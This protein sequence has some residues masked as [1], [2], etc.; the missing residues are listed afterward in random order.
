M[1]ATTGWLRV[2]HANGCDDAALQRIVR[3]ELGPASVLRIIGAPVRGDPLQAWGDLGRALGPPSRRRS[4]A[5][6]WTELRFEPERMDLFRHVN[7][8]HPLHTDSAGTGVTLYY[9]ERRGRGGDSL[10]VDAGAVAAAARRRGG[11]LFERLFEVP[12]S[13]AKGPITTKPR[14]ILRRQ[15]DRLK[16]AWDYYAVAPGQG[17]EVDALREDFRAFLEAMVMDGDACA[18][19]LETGDA[20]FALADEVLH[21]RAAGPAKLAGKP[22]GEQILWKASLG[23]NPSR[24]IR[25]A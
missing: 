14:P 6:A 21:G 2:I 20:I 3:K 1:S 7:L 16:I 4:D 10:F 24:D 9:V 23:L 19:R 13:F 5:L 18:L 22:V 17:G 12:V 11:D 25:A 15:D 8:T